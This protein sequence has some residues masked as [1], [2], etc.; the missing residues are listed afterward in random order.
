MGSQ[1]WN[2]LY[3]ELEIEPSAQKLW[4]IEIWKKSILKEGFSLICLKSLWENINLE[5]THLIVFQLNFWV[6]KKKMCIIASFQLF[7]IRMSF[8]DEDWLFIALRTRIYL[9]DWWINYFAYLTSLKWQEQQAF[10]FSI[11]WLEDSKSKLLQCFIE[12]LLSM[13]W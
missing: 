9:Y 8:Q 1:D 3:Q 12:R 5:H 13:E 2:T 11:L 7:S 10:L 4:V 6:N